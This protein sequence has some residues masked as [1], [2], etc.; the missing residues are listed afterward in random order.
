MAIFDKAYWIQYITRLVNRDFQNISDEEDALLQGRQL[1]QE[2]DEPIERIQYKK[3]RP[4]L[5][6]NALAPQPLIIKEVGKS[7][8]DTLFTFIRSKNVDEVKLYQKIG[9]SRSVFSRIRSDKQYQPERDNVYRFAIGLEL[10][11]DEAI[12]LLQ[13]AGYY[14]KLNSRTS[15]VIRHCLANGIYELMAVDEILVTNHENPLFSSK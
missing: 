2:H 8:S 5:F 12:Q 15:L 14:F 9:I 11:L 7:F 3:V 10:N 13:S 4:G 6:P 1:H